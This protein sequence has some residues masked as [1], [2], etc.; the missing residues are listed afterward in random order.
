M[1]VRINESMPSFARS[2]AFPMPVGATAE[3]I[4]GLITLAA[5]AA[6][7]LAQLPLKSPFLKNI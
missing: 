7:E 3:A 5:I 4:K 6:T 2:T 1:S